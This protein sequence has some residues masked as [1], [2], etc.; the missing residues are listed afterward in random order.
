MLAKM[1]RY[2]VYVLSTKPKKGFQL[3]SDDQIFIN[4]RDTFY[5][6]GYKHHKV[7]KYFDLW[8]TH[9][10]EKDIDNFVTFGRIVRIDGELYVTKLGRFLVCEVPVS[11]QD[12]AASSRSVVLGSG[13]SLAKPRASSSLE[14]PE[15]MYAASRLGLLPN[16]GGKR[17]PR[18]VAGVTSRSTRIGKGF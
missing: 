10:K 9:P 12:I 3:P 16:Q 1:T 18:L 4:E 17:I 7:G 11:D 14:R 13:R 2:K 5:G 15:H 8:F 6:Y